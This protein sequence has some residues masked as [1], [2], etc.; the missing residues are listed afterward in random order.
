MTNQV[1]QIKRFMLRVLLAAGTTPLPDSALIDAVI[2]GVLPRPL[3]ADAVIA[4]NQLEEG[5]FIVGTLDPI[6]ET[7]VWTLTQAGTLQAKQR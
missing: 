6:D 7:T 4:R 3:R 5:D 2:H 1:P